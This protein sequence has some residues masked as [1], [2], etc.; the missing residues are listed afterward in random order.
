MGGVAYHAQLCVSA[1]H[2][3]LKTSGD[4]HCA[5]MSQSYENE[6]AT[7]TDITL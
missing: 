1:A 3:W 7:L 2:C 5:H 4:K 6:M